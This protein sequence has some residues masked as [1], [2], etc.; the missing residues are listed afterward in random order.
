ME[1]GM[2][3]GI[4]VSPGIGL[5]RAIKYHKQELVIPEGPGKGV[6]AERAAFEQVLQTIIRE[7][8]SLAENARQTIGASEA[9]IFDAHVMILRDPELSAPI[10]AAIEAGDNAAHA[11]STS[12][13]ALIEFFASMDDAYMRERAADMKDIKFRLLCELLGA[14]CRDLSTLPEMSIIVANDLAPSDTAKIDKAHIAGIVTEVGG[15]TSHTAI[16]AR[17]MEIPAI[18]G[19]ANAL[20]LI[21]EGSLIAIDGTTGIVTLNLSDDDVR[22]F[23]ARIQK[24]AAEKASLNRFATAKSITKDGRT[25]EI[26][27]NIGV[28]GEARR[29][30]NL[31]ADGI[32]LFR[33]EL[34]YMDRNNLPDEDEQFYAYKEA[35]CA[36]DGKPVIVRTLDIGGDKKLPALPLPQE[37]NP[38]LGYRAIRISLDREELFKTQI[39]ALL[40]AS[41]FGQLKIMFPMIS[42]LDELR[43]AKALVQ[44][45]MQELQIEGVA[46]DPDVQVG[47][48]IEVPAAA[49]LA[50]QLA[51]ECDFF[52][53]GTNDLIQ[54]TVAV[55]R[56]NEKVAGLY[57]QYHPAVLRLID[58]TISSAHAAGI[59]CG[60]CGEAA[61]DLLLIP[62]FLGMGLD[63]FS[64]SPSFILPARKLITELDFSS[65]QKMVPEVIGLSTASE[66]QIKLQSFSD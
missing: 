38:F 7:T 5:A 8:E 61:G 32:G 18:V 52:S 63:E 41:A 26:A 53:I 9:A 25:V 58:T 28:P 35:L 1:D 59:P 34:L 43:R 39:R 40:R 12:M 50:D 15:R 13:D 51:K 11:V 4:G 55:D 10:I 14:K 49:L 33:S 17:A 62:L 54:Y 57:S 65:C 24:A 60:M 23:Q 3:K 16:M 44:N 22:E 21:E 47:I 29:A 27:A 45:C 36:M 64:M 19:C 56:G 20:E 6:E 30:A 48:M 46:Y 37:E 42:S 66:V 2:L 31:G